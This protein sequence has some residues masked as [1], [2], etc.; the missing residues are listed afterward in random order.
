M[1]A[2]RRG[3]WTPTSTPRMPI[4]TWWPSSSRERRS[5][6][7]QF[8]YHEYGGNGK[9]Y[10]W[11]L[12][13]IMAFLGSLAVMGVVGSYAWAR[14]MATLETKMDQIQIDFKELKIEVSRDYPPRK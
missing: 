10:K 11:F 6:G 4:W 5:T 8:N 14:E 3:A 12:G 1:T 2:W 7:E 9:I 13:G